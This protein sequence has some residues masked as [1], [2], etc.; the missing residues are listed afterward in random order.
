[1]PIN[2]KSIKSLKGV[3]PIVATTAYDAVMATLADRAGVD[4][5]LVGDSVGTTLLGFDSTV[6]VNLEMMV[7]HTSAV[8]RVN[9]NALVVSDLPFGYSYD[10][11]DVIF[12]ACR[13]LIQSG[14]CSAV[15]IEGGMELA[16]TVKR[17][18]DS[19]I[20]ILGHIGL[21]PQQI[22]NLGAY[23]KFGKSSAENEQLIQDAKALEAS[24]CFA[25][26]GEMIDAQVARQ[27]TDALDVP[28][29]GIG[30]GVHCD[31]Q[32]LVSNDLLGFTTQ[33]VPSFVQSFGA[34]SK[35]VS[36]A[37]EKY[38]KAVRERHFPNE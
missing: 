18:V 15:K 25:I 24:G 31:G 5:L 21:L 16:P 34:L 20:P 35:E 3:R 10:Q 32:I 6:Q 14:G 2:T 33:K 26:V 8:S 1:V 28:L 38:K 23:R 11:Y 4:L 22:N 27:I 19:G 7:H 30:S 13:T 12:N 36:F 37:F 9:P 29:I 17:L